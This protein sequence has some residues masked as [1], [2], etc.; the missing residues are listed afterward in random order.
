MDLMK[1]DEWMKVFIMDV[2]LLG[3]YI[4][5]SCSIIINDSPLPPPWL[6][7]LPS[8][9]MNDLTNKCQGNSNIN[10]WQFCPFMFLLRF[11]YKE[12]TS[13]SY[14]VFELKQWMGGIVILAR[15]H[16][17]RV[18]ENLV[19]HPS[20]YNIDFIKTNYLQT[21]VSFKPETWNVFLNKKKQ[22]T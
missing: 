22:H 17:I 12:A 16:F 9:W 21:E 8:F 7:S 19:Q 18:H 6:H 11:L 2:L 20:N 4:R 1:I 10:G 5:L 15:C 3:S 14:S 13:W